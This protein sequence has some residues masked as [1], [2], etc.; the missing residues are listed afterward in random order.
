MH[1]LPVSRSDAR[2]S[3]SHF[4]HGQ[5]APT[6]R[7]FDAHSDDRVLRDL[8]RLELRVPGTEQRLRIVVF[9]PVGQDFGVSAQHDPAEQGPIFVVAID[10]DGDRRILGD[11]PQALQ[12]G[13]GM[14]ASVFRRS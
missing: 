1:P 12:R 6:R 7:P 4:R 10:D 9:R 14:L 2:G 8:H 5:I 13:A 11:I 3:Q